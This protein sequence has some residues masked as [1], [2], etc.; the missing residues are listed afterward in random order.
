MLKWFTN[1]LSLDLLIAYAQRLVDQ[2]Q[3]HCRVVKDEISLASVGP[4]ET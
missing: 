3:Y 4:L 1:L 2:Y